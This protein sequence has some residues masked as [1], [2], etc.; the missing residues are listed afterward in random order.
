MIS[1]ASDL[2][3]IVLKIAQVVALFYAGYKFTRKPHDTLDAR[4]TN[5]EKQQAQ[6]ELTLTEL[7]KAEDAS[8]EKHR[9]QDKTNNVFKRVMLLLAN[10]E[11]AF[12]QSTNYAGT[13]DLIKA[14]DE[15][16]KYLTGD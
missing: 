10:F 12:C 11:V 15:L 13:A 6:T 3:G 2:L 7:K 16:E 9:A 8:H 4:V 5:L 1:T 14:K